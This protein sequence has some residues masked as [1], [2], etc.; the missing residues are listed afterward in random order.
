MG[1]KIML[2]GI[3]VILAGIALSISNIFALL[4]EPQ[5]FNHNC[6]Y[7]CTGQ[8]HNRDIIHGGLTNDLHDRDHFYFSGMVRWA[9]C[10]RKHRFWRPARISSA[11]GAVSCLAMGI[12]I[13]KALKESHKS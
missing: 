9:I 1:I 3:A 11:Q 12:C 4:V 6:R 2:L 13:L 5:V 10:R 8:K 7:V